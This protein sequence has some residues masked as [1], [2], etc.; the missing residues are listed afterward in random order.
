VLTATSTS[1]NVTV[2]AGAG[3]NNIAVTVNNLTAY[4]PQLFMPV[5]DGGGASLSGTSF[6]AILPVS[7]GPWNPTPSSPVSADIDGDGKV[8]IVTGHAN[9]AIVSVLKNKSTVGFLVFDTATFPCNSFWT[10]MLKTPDLDGDGR[11]DIA[12]TCY[13]NLLSFYR[14]TSAPGTVSF[15]PRIDLATSGT[16]FGM[17]TGDL[18]GDGRPDIV[19]PHRQVQTWRPAPAERHINGR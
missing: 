15:A 19:I 2:P 3:Y 14:N 13:G 17:A 8:D 16:S 9:R 11:L 5:F 7:T 1:L 12:T 10:Y 6:E 4:S 18:D